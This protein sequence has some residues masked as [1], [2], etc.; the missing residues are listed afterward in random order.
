MLLIILT[1]T[2]SVSPCMRHGCSFAST[3][4]C[5]TVILCRVRRSAPLLYIKFATCVRQWVWLIQRHS[6]RLFHIQR[7][8]T[9]DVHALMI[10]LMRSDDPTDAL[11]WDLNTAA[12]PCFHSVITISI[13]Y[14]I[15]R[16]YIYREILC[17]ERFF[18]FCLLI[19]L[20]EFT[21]DPRTWQYC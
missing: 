9:L 4:R 5:N 1:V 3:C 6:A 10:Q 18:F 2:R 8:D 13:L 12:S 11:L 19:P 17:K 20:W 7:P 15:Y 16:D 21:S 14:E